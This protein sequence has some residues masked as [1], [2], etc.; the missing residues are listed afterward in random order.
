MSYKYQFSVIYAA[1]LLK[2]QC[3]PPVYSGLK[4]LKANFLFLKSFIL[5][6]N[7]CLNSGLCW[8]QGKRQPRHWACIC[9]K[10]GTLSKAGRVAQQLC[11]R[12][13]FD[14]VNR[15]HCVTLSRVVCC[16]ETCDW[17]PQRDVDQKVEP[18]S[19][20][21]TGQICDKV[22]A[23]C[24]GER[25]SWTSGSVNWEWQW[26]RCLSLQRGICC[27]HSLGRIGPGSLPWNYPL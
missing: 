20:S 6:V 15:T 12:E 1:F 22:V 18:G 4:C 8:K 27:E 10:S 25:L 11:G 5:T 24:V 21:V 14:I 26:K 17:Q 23:S 19:V 3:I 2:P 7:F 9:T 13:Q 16:V